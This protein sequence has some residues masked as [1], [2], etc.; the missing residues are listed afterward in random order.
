MERVEKREKGSSGGF[1]RD[2]GA[3]LRNYKKTVLASDLICC[4][5]GAKRGGRHPKGGKTGKGPPRC[6]GREKKR[7]KII[8]AVAKRGENHCS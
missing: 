8:S 2:E 1:G 5:R 4:S 7:G 3:L 6:F